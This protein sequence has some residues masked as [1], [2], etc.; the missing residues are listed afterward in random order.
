GVRVM[1]T[2]SIMIAANASYTAIGFDFDSVG[3]LSNGRD[4]DPTTADVGGALDRYIG[5]NV[6]VGY[7]F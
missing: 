4:G 2:E 3:D 7:S 6:A 1:A 5:G